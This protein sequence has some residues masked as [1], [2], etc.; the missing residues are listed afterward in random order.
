MIH[1]SQYREFA[2]GHR[3]NPMSFSRFMHQQDESLQGA[4][5]KG[6]ADQVT[7]DELE[8][9]HLTVLLNEAAEALLPAEG[10]VLV[11]GTLGGGGHTEL[12]LERGAIVYSIDRDPDALNYAKRRLARFGDRFRPLEGNFSEMEK[13]ITA[14][15]V[16]KVD[17]VL[18]DIG[19]SSHQFDAAERGFSFSKNGPLDMRMGPSCPNTASDIINNWGEQE[20]AGIFW[21]FGEERS[22]RKIAKMIVEKRELTPFE[23]TTQL[24]EA[25]ETLLP[26]FGK[27]IHPATKVFQALRIEVNNELGELRTLLDSAKNI[28]KPGGRF[29]VISFHSLEDRMVKRHFR[30]TSQKEVDKPEWP[31]PRPNPDYAYKLITKKPIV[32]SP[33]EVVKN[34]RSR[35]ALLRV[36]EREQY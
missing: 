17:G 7:A 8:H 30:A 32:A 28:I 31:A 21:Q 27:K 9:Y 15:G 16:Q 3:K 5:L 18:V 22:S 23:T 12:L 24:A 19:V 2:D 13:L 11:D 25:I 36:V 10:K 14:E 6:S 1:P 20:L 33:Q 29:A 26:R 34:P 35:S 4:Q